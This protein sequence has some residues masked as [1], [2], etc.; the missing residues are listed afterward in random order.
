M[1]LLLIVGYGLDKRKNV[2]LSIS[3]TGGWLPIQTEAASE[4][5][6]QDKVEEERDWDLVDDSVDFV[7]PGDLGWNLEVIDLC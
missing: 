6:V 7:C 3:F 4:K 2:H 1:S 5:K